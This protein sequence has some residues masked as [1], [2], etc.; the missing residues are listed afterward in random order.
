[1]ALGTK[2]RILDATVGLLR[3][4]GYA[5]TGLK[6]IAV[7]SHAPWSSLYHFFPGGKDEL[8][9]DALMVAGRRYESTIDR[10]FKESRDGAAATRAFLMLSVHA[11]ER[12]EFADGCP[13]A[14]AALEAASTSDRLRTTAA[15]VFQF[16]VNAAAAKFQ[17]EGLSSTR[18][19]EI[20]TFALAT[21]EGAIILSRTY[22]ST[23]PLKQCAEMLE[24]AIRAE[25]AA[26][27]RRPRKGQ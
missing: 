18:A 13:I 21:F 25:I 8:V 24:R 17:S 7:T 20:A 26:R 27:P 5:G 23:E 6:Q 19:R 11:L 16:W 1:M 9:E 15:T 14:T 22:K 12:S 10:L 3:R 4:Q 2:D